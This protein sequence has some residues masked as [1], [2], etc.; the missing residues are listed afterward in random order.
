MKIEAVSPYK[1]LSAFGPIDLPALTILTGPNG[2]GKSQLLAGLYYQA[3][4]CDLIAPLSQASSPQKADSNLNAAGDH[5]ITLIRNSV[6]DEDQFNSEVQSKLSRQ[7]GGP[8]PLVKTLPFYINGFDERREGRLSRN[9]K[10]LESVLNAS[11]QS[12]VG[13]NE[14]PWRLGPNTLADRGSVAKTSARRREII[15]IFEDAA[16]ELTV[17]VFGPGDV[18]TLFADAILETAS[19]FG[20]GILDVTQ[21]MFEIQMNRLSAHMFQPNVQELFNVYRDLVFSNDMNEVKARRDPTQKFLN[22][23]Q[24]TKKYGPPP[25]AIISDLLMAMALPFEV[26]PPST[27]LAQPVRFQLRHTERR[28]ELGFDALSSGEKVLL[29]FA[30]SFIRPNLRMA[31][32]QRPLLLL[33]DEM[34][35]SLHP[36]MVQRW[37]SAIE[38]EIVGKLGIKVIL[39]THSPTTVALAP[40]HS[41]FVM[42]N[43]IP[44]QVTKQEAIN[45]LTFGVPTLSIDYS[46][47]RQVFCEN[48]SDAAAYQA[49]Y[50]VIKAKI[51]H[52]KELN[53]IGTGIVKKENKLTESRGEAINTGAAVVK[54]I[55]SNLT[56]RGAISVYGIIDWDMKA[57]TKGRVFVIGEGSHRAIEN[58]LL[59]PLLIGAL[60]HH[61]KITLPDFN[62]EQGDLKRLNADELQK[63]A[64]RVQ[65]KL[66]LPDDD[67]ELIAISYLGGKTINIRKRFATIDAKE[68]EKR[69]GDWFET[70]GCKKPDRG[71]LVKTVSTKVIRMNPDLCPLI[72]SK[73]FEQI[74]CAE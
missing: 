55:V 13:V 9:R 3:I 19:E 67:R 15:R 29:R 58:I 44:T 11:L 7:L 68:L 57:V 53:F 41:I 22:T 32:Y 73:L 17:K 36:E 34:D 4:G 61:Y 66:I 26:M 71:S 27:D 46:G 35:A 5:R 69:V 74:S 49:I 20:V 8:P 48:G 47:Q 43:G 38:R 31:G 60:L 42:A 72:I 62:C 24:F 6:P 18:D 39:T 10:R 28:K 30:V 12:L 70:L 51:P 40:E 59:D 33:L 14:D 23:E 52:K 37:L 1:S 64:D 63:I 25:W 65:S 45:K 50:S 16:S 2:S 21:E 54:T 56:E